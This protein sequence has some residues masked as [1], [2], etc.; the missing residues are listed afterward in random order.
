MRSIWYLRECV[1]PCRHWKK[2]LCSLTAIG[3]KAFAFTWVR[4]SQSTTQKNQTQASVL[5]KPTNQWTRQEATDGRTTLVQH[6]TIKCTS[7]LQHRQVHSGKAN[8]EEKAYD[9]EIV[10]IKP[11]TQLM[12]PD[13]ARQHIRKSTVSLQ[14]SMSAVALHLLATTV[15]QSF[16]VTSA[17][18]C[19]ILSRKCCR[20]YTSSRYLQSQC[21][22]CIFDLRH[23]SQM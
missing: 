13:S 9:S 3:F 12:L 21:M 11:T 23:L 15:A 19:N 22:M 6:Q 20:S 7:T 14:W 5:S 1:R 4:V 18:L 8:K 2:M 10:S 16:K 17:T